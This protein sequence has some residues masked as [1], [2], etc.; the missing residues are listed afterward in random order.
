MAKAKNLPRYLKARTVEEQIAVLET[1]REY[2][3]EEGPHWKSRLRD[4]WQ[5]GRDVGPLRIARNTCAAWINAGVT[6]ADLAYNLEK[7]QNLEKQ[8][9]QG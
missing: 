8:N 5:S 1:L 6:V 9:G 7:L 4:L 2:A 3:N